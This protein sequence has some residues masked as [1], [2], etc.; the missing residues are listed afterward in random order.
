MLAELPTPTR[1]RPKRTPVQMT[2]EETQK[3]LAEYAG[4]YP[5]VIG[6]KEASEITSL[7]ISTLHRKV[8][9]NKYDDCV[10]RGK[11]LK[12]HRDKLVRRLLA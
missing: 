1:S 12:F 9:Q 6:I 10:K 8:S 4:K 2:P 5:P 7:A 3:T 11:P